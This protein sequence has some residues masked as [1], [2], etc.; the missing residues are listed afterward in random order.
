MNIQNTTKSWSII[1]T[2]R[3]WPFAG[4]IRFLAPAFLALFL[5]VSA[6]AAS[7]TNNASGNWGDPGSWANSAVGASGSDTIIWFNNNS[8]GTWS[9]T[10]NNAGT[11]VLSG[12]KMVTGSKGINLYPSGG[13]SLLFT[14]SSGGILPTITGVAQIL[15]VY[16]PITLATNLTI[17]HATAG[18]TIRLYGNIDG[19]GDITLQGSSTIAAFGIINNSGSITNSGPGAADTLL[20]SGCVISNNVKAIVQNSTSSKLSVANGAAASANATFALNILAGT[21]RWNGGALNTN[22]VLTISPTGVFEIFQ[23][24]ITIAGINDGAGGGG[25]AWNNNGQTRGLV[26]GGT[27]SYSFSGQ[28][29]DNSATSLTR[30]TLSGSG[31]QTLGGS[32]SFSAGMTVSGGTL[33]LAHS[34]A[35]PN[36]TVTLSGGAVVFDSSVSGNAFNFGGLAAASAG[37]GYDMGLTNNAGTAIALTVGGNNASTTYAGVLSGT[38]GGLNKLGTGTLTLTATNTYT[39]STDILGGTLTVSGAGMLGNGDYAGAISNNAALVYGSTATQTLSGVISG[40]G[41]LTQQAGVLLLNGVSTDPNQTVVVSGG[42]LGGT[43]TISGPVSVSAGF[44][45]LAPSLGTGGSNTLNLSSTLTLNSGLNLKFALLPSGAVTNDQIAVSG[46]LTLNGVNY[47]TLTFPGGAV[48]AGDYTL[49]TYSSTNGTG[50]L[51]LGTAY[52]NATLAVNNT[53][54]KLTV[55]GSGTAGGSLATRWTGLVNG[56]WDTTTANWTNGAGTATYSDGKNVEFDSLAVTAKRTVTNNSGTIFQ[57]GSVTFNTNSVN[58]IIGANIGGSGFLALNGSGSATLNGTNSYTGPTFI[59]AGTLTIGG[60]GQ[61]GGGN[62]AGVITHNGAAL[63]FASSAPN[64]L[65]GGITKGV[66][67]AAPVTSSGTGLL[68]LSGVNSIS[69]LTVSTG[70]TV[71]ANTTT[72][73]TVATVGS[74]ANSPATL[75]LSN[76]TVTSVSASEIGSTLG[77]NSNLVVVTGGSSIWNGSAADFRVGTGSTG[78]LVR[79]ENGGMITNI[80]LRQGNGASAWGNSLIITN[81][82]KV[83]CVAS[84]LGFNTGANGNHV[85]ITGGGSILF[86]GTA[87]FLH[88]GYNAAASGNWVKV[89]LGGIVTNGY[90]AVG[91][92]AK[93]SGNYLIITNG[94][95]FFNTGGGGLIGRSAGC[96]YNWV[97]V[98]GANGSTNALWSFAAQSLGIAAAA[99]TG[100]YMNVTGGGTVTGVT[101]LA[102]GNVAGSHT[103]GVQVTG[104]GLLEVNTSI[105]VGNASS[106]GNYLTNSGGILQFGLATPPITVSPNNT[107]VITNG[108][109]SF[110]NVNPFNLTNNWV[111]SGIGTNTVNWLPGGNNTLR[112]DGSTATNTLVRPYQFNTGFGSTNY[113]ALELLN[114]SFIKGNE[115]VIGTNGTMTLVSGATAVLSGVT[116][117]YGIL[118]GSGMVSGLVAM[119]S[120]STLS[121]TGTETLSFSSNLTFVGSSGSIT[122]N[123][124]Y[125]SSTCS[126]VRVGGTLQLPPDV[127]LNVTNI[128]GNI[129]E[130]LPPSPVVFAW[131]SNANS[132]V[133]F[134]V[135][136]DLYRV[137]PLGSTYVLMPSARGCMMIIQ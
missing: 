93:S 118:A 48:P 110:R 119:A 36:S 18:G 130:P 127:Y 114:T 89:E 88:I 71:I 35:V 12:L 1:N 132:S 5:A 84:S 66:G 63:N 38:G 121:P 13:S 97:T 50:S 74:V 58:Y 101:T 30:L 107:F 134:H 11:F 79:V 133:T 102:V 65:S 135:T 59:N 17:S 80:T 75:I 10:N 94:G 23:D 126:V 67:T 28:I 136:P 56:N 34:N 43:G 77:A 8:A 73:S 124:S 122:C 78:N 81:G 125:T 86:P 32:N 26:L 6:Q 47:I 57:P 108:T 54:V 72:L 113:V 115:I 16:S 46:A 33:K 90:A 85:I 4:T 15:Y 123:W 95:K 129:S 100:N 53:S 120:G 116:T 128:S 104:G 103:N 29:N 27:N 69:A 31:T 25:L 64:T 22:I 91:D 2:H 55:S 87:D 14:N 7:Y 24:P 21:V 45:V 9:S 61:L 131:G 39:G 20:D 40:T 99:S 106:A 117:N 3:A 92:A 52:S 37:A 137:N 96:N 70:T 41:S 62:Y 83:S 68:T 51:L 98:G 109:V 112:L 19:T 49:M 111:N 105:T 60:A 42:A 82:G 76:G 44:G